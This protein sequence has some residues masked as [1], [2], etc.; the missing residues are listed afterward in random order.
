MTNNQKIQVY[1]NPWA[2]KNFDQSVAQ[3]FYSPDSSA[4]QVVEEVQPEPIYQP[5]PERR[6]GLRPPAPQPKKQRKTKQATEFAED[7]QARHRHNFLSYVLV[8]AFFGG[9]ALILALNARFEY[10][11]MALEAAR[12]HLV[13]VHNG[14]AARASEIYATLDLE[15]IEAFAIE[16]L[17]MIQPEEFQ[18]MEVVVTPQSFFA[19]SPQDTPAAGGFSLERFWNILFSFDSTDGQE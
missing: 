2:S 17:G 18:M 16:Y 12:D 7:I 3:N 15:A 19:A 14:N 5:E 9:L 8:L 4:R 6:G 11:R 1:T 13:A 10:D